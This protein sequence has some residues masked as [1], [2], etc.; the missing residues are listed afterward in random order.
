[1]KNI[2]Q[3]ANGIVSFG[4]DIDPNLYKS[5]LPAGF[6]ATATTP[7]APGKVFFKCS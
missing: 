3:V 1:M 2:Y 7:M 6:Y 5:S 4:K